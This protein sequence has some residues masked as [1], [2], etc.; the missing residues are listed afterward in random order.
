MAQSGYD[1]Y[2]NISSGFSSLDIQKPYRGLPKIK[3]N[4]KCF[5]GFFAIFRNDKIWVPFYQMLFSF[6]TW[7]ISKLPIMKTV[8]LR[9]N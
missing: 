7:F 3:V 9:G 2:G 8:Q 4:V 6:K 5:K 1:Y